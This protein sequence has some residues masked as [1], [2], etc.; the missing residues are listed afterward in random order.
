MDVHIGA[1]DGPRPSLTT[2][3]QQVSDEVRSKQDAWL[4]ALATDPQ[5]LAQVEQEIH[6]TFADLADQVTAAVLTQASQHPQMQCHQKKRSMLRW[7]PLAPR[8]SAR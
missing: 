1:K 2:V 4:D 7:F 5:R 6:K 8:R 3:A